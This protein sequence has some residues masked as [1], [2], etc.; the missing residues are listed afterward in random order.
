MDHVTKTFT[1]PFSDVLSQSNNETRC[2]P[3]HDLTI[4][5]HTVESGMHQKATFAEHRLDV[6]RHLHVSGIHTF[7]LQD[8]RIE[9]Q[10]SRHGLIESVS[11]GS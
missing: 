4:I 5:K 2:A 6:E 11:Y 10:K 9:F 7:V 3:L 1:Y 8:D